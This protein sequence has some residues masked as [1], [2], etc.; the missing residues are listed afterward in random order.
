MTNEQRYR[1]ALERIVEISNI[2]DLMPLP[3]SQ[4]M[5]Q[6][7]EKALAPTVPLVFCPRVN[8]KA[9]MPRVMKDALR[10][11]E[12]NASATGAK[13]VTQDEVRKFLTDRHGEE[14]ADWF[15]PEYLQPAGP[16]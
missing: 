11:L 3:M 14:F 6:E 4:M 1:R 5:L 16:Q 7:A 9:K 8:V 15:K 10:S 2:V 12:A 13:A